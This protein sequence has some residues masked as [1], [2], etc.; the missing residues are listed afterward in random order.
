MDKGT[1]AFGG[2]LIAIG[3]LILVSTLTGIDFWA[4]CWPTGLIVL[5]ILLIWRTTAA[6]AD[7]DLQQKLLGDITR[8]GV[9]Q[10]SDS[11][12]WTIIGD[13]RLDLTEAEI[14][15][16]ETKLRV[17]G[18][19]GDT[20]IKVPESVGLSVTSTAFVTDGKVFGEKQERFASTLRVAS[21]DYETAARRVRILATRLVT[22]LKVERV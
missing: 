17:Y 14:P 11:E 22:T 21:D 4:F 6:S 3:V 13:V 2:V 16:G 15:L 1:L 20:R 19:V 12:L 18:F 7:T 9:W 10:V 5:G 8:K